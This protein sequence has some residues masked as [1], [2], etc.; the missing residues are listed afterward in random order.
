[1]LTFA[2]MVGCL[3]GDWMIS[4]VLGVRWVAGC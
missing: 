1:M 4:S 3:E 2:Q